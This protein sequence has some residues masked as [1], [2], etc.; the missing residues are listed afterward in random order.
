MKIA[1]WSG[2]RNLSTAM[3]YSFGNRGDLRPWDEPFYA[4]YLDATKIDH[5]MRAEIL[6]AGPTDAQAVA[7]Q[8]AE[9]GNAQFL[10][11]MTFHMLDGFPMEWG[12]DCQHFH[13]IR[14]PARVIASYSKKR[15]SP[16]LEDIGFDAHLEIYRRFPG[17]VVSSSDMRKD[18]R[19]MLQKLCNALGSD[20]DPAMLNWPKGPKAFDGV[21]APHW[22]DAVHRSTGFAGAEGPLPVLEGRDAALCEAALPAYDAM[23]VHKI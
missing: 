15:E 6:S 10:K 7:D 20:F 8:I 13:L 11:L 23:A 4:A 2:P 5:P 22:Y 19:G 16:T 3:M 21:W 9:R 12:Q 18:P 17:P 14:H 1:M